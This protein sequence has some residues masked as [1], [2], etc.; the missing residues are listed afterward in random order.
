MRVR[1]VVA[2][3]FL[4]LGLGCVS[5]QLRPI[6]TS[7]PA[8]ST[9]T[10]GGQSVSCLEVNKTGLPC[11]S[12]SALTQESQKCVEADFSAGYPLGYCCLTGS[13]CCL[14]ASCWLSVNAHTDGHADLTFLLLHGSRFSVQTWIEL[15]TMAVLAKHGLHAVAVDLPGHGESPNP[16]VRLRTPSE[17]GEWLSLLM[18]QIAPTSK[19]V[20]V[21]PSMSG[22]GT[23]S[24]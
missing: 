12:A 5:G 6:M 1:V 14:T 23:G 15:G 16:M 17:R 22:Y 20:L 13:C 9:L 7:L 19:V 21:S 3:V 18:K 24:F 11:T 4:E 8:R 10:V 2:L